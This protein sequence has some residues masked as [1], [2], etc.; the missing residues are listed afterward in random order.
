MAQVIKI[1]R[2]TTTAT[3][4][5]LAAG[6]LAYSDNS[7]K[8]FIGAPADSAVI[9]IG[10]KLYVDMLDHTAGTLT[11]DS[12]IVVDSS[13]KIDQ[14]KT[15]NL[16]IGANSITSGSGDIDLVAAANLDIDAGTL[17]FTTQAT[18]FSLID[19]SATALTISEGANVYVQIDTTNAAERI[20]FNKQ[21]HI[22][23]EYTLPTLDGTNGQALITNGNGTVS[24]QTISTSL[25]IAGDT[26]T[27]TVSL[28]SDTFTFTG[29]EGIDT[30]VTNNTLTITAETATS[31]NLGVASFDATDFTVSSGAVTANAITLGTSSLNLGETT[32]TL[33]GLQQLDV[34]NVQ[35]DGN[36]ISTTDAN[37]NLILSPN[38]T[39]VV[40]VPSGY[41]DRTQFGTNSL[42]TK[43]YV[44]ALK[45]SLDIKDSVKVATTADL[46][47][48]YNNGAGTLTNAG[49]NVALSIDTV[50]LS[51]GDR[52]L[53]KDQSSQ[54]EN[55]IYTVTTVGDGSTP[56][57]LTRAE[58]ADESAE[59]TGGVFTFV[60]DGSS[61]ADNGY[62]FTHNGAPTLGTTS[63]PVSQFSGAGQ[64]IAGDAL[65]KT[66]NTLNVNDD[67][68]TLEISSDALRIKGISATAAGDLLIGAAANA[69]YTALAK[70]STTA[71]AY[72]YL[73]SMDSSG[74][75]RWADTL[76]GGTF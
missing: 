44:D 63:L 29:G 52:V 56:W 54:A 39:G 73:L 55:G 21:V 23:N 25:D 15:A 18:E 34:D 5:T 19:N 7:D 64:I 71:T 32:S 8:L 10:G 13:S 9:A 43:E 65:S 31:S 2:S 27:D 28:I 37:G 42:V 40:N 57:V 75:A 4:S 1:K 17:D 60:E 68:I 69:G 58:D 41:K 70:P 24:F 45:Q 11:A 16:T 67:N 14:L 53:V 38:G 26:G 51:S 74:N 61:N 48:T 6:E 12:A 66:G 20:I 47:A 3:P 46:G 72:T 22:G 49:A 50:S 33:A 35:I 59:L 62:V 30:A 36:T 76:D